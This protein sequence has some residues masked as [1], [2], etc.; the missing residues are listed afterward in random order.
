M[1]VGNPFSTDILE[2]SWYV[3]V[4]VLFPFHR[5]GAETLAMTKYRF[6]HR[7]GDLPIADVVGVEV[8][9]VGWIWP[10]SCGWWLWDCVVGFLDVANGCFGEPYVGASKVVRDRVRLIC[11]IRFWISVYES[12]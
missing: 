12:V 5:A 8:V 4:S 1:V 3:I 2:M 7:F 9:A 10:D 6:D 11:Y